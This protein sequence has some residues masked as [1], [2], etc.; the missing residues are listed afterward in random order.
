MRV[1]AIRTEKGFLIPMTDEF[2]NIKQNKIMLNIQ[3]MVQKQIDEDYSS[4]DRLIGLCE[5]GKK[6]ASVNHDEIIYRGKE[7]DD[8]Y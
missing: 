6:N 1:E 5:T 3:F 4:L 2:R 8:L 7:K